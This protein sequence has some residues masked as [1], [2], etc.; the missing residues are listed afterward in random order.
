[1]I[2]IDIRIWACWK[3]CSTG[4]KEWNSRLFLEFTDGT[5]SVSEIVA[6]QR[7]EGPAPTVEATQV[8]TPVP[9]AEIE[10]SGPV[11]EGNA[12]SAVQAAPV[13]E[14]LSVTANRLATRAT[15]LCPATREATESLA[16]QATMLSTATKG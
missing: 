5:V 8:S 2:R 6:A 16:G 7:G 12:R 10:A 1:M 14:G 13:P 3:F 9:T 15:T 4:I 11:V